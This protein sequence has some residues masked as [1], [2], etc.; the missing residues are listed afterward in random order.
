M[1]RSVVRVNYDIEVREVQRTRTE[2]NA[3]LVIRDQVWFEAPT[4]LDT[5]PNKQNKIEHHIFSQKETE[6]KSFH[7]STY[8]IFVIQKKDVP[9]NKCQRG[10]TIWASRQALLHKGLAG[11]SDILEI[12][13]HSNR[14]KSVVFSAPRNFYNVRKIIQDYSHP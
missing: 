6:L 10:K 3:K 11:A 7:D 2:N 12:A 13:D 14:T 9:L 1:T 8:G 4:N 5:Q